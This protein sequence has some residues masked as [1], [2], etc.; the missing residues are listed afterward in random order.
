MFVWCLR[1]HWKMAWR[2]QNG[3]HKFNAIIIHTLVT[4]WMRIYEGIFFLMQF[5]IFDTHQNERY[6]VWIFGQNWF[7]RSDKV[8]VK[9]VNPWHNKKISGFSRSRLWLLRQMSKFQKCGTKTKRTTSPESC[10]CKRRLNK[11]KTIQKLHKICP[12]TLFTASIHTK[13]GREQFF[14]Q[15][16]NSEQ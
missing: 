14:S 7:G 8:Q 16:S 2:K 11:G 15:N 4:C 5:V 10:A 6:L 13:D 3:D 12:S 1:F 9:I